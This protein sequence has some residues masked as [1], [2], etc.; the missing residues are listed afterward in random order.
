MSKMTGRMSICS[1]IGICPS[2]HCPAIDS[3]FPILG[4]NSNSGA[5]WIAGS[6]VSIIRTSIIFN[7]SIASFFGLPNFSAYSSSKMSLTAIAQSLKI[8]LTGTG[9]HVGINYIGFAENESQ[10]TFYCR[11]L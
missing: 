4:E 9:I 6:F 7:S 2:I 10:K 3:R 8:E 1:I 5:S 11:V